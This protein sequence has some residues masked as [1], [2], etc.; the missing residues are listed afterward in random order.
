MGS[1]IRCSSCR[2][3]FDKDDAVFNAGLSRLCSEACVDAYLTK[4]RDHS[5]QDRKRKPTRSKAQRADRPRKPHLTTEM[6]EQIRKRDGHCCRFCGKP[7]DLQIHHIRYRSEGGPDHELNLI[8]LC[9]EH[10][11][12]VHS[13]KRLWQPVLL[14]SI[15][16]LYVEQR[17]MTI[18]EVDRHLT[19]LGMRQT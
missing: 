10:H 12:L 1:R 4:R 19:R 2:S 15:W 6:R 8:T 13:N 7:R 16:L 18:P 17:R 9:Q 3:Y 5:R 14:A 11:S